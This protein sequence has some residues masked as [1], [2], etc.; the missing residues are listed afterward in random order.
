MNPRQYIAAKI[1]GDCICVI[2][3]MSQGKLFRIYP[4]GECTPENWAIVSALAQKIQSIFELYVKFLETEKIMFPGVFGKDMDVVMKFVN[5]NK[6]PQFVTIRIERE[7]INFVEI[8]R[9]I[10]KA[11]K[12]LGGPGEY[13]FYGLELI[14]IE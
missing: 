5:K 4:F 14:P 11:S 1:N 6:K 3:E 8:G 10:L 7:S 13:R 2:K 12:R 9:E